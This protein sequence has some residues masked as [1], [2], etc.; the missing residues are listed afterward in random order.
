MSKSQQRRTVHTNPF[1]FAMELGFFA[2]LFWGGARWIMYTLHFTKVIPGFLAEPFFKHDFLLKPAG[3][4]IGYLSFIILSVIAALIY[5]FAFRWLKGPWP[6]M[7]YGVLWWA[8]LFL[9]GS[10]LFL[11][12]RPFRL[13]WNSVISE[14]C[15]FLLWGLFIGYTAAMEYTDERKRERKSIL[16]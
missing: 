11:L 10:W 5:V 13:P 9:A 2:G 4:L 3:H 15:V 1:V 8:G 14:F 12:Q 16:T 7:I 6:G